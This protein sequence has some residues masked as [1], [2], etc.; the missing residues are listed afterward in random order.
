MVNAV[1][2]ISAGLLVL[3]G[4][5]VP[6]LSFLREILLQW[7]TILAAFALLVGVTNL[8]MVHG[9]KVGKGGEAAIYSFVTI[10][11]FVLTI[12][13]VGINKPTGQWSTRI[14]NSIT[15]PVENSL[16]ALLSISLLYAVMRLFRRKMDFYTIIFIVTMIL[17]LL[18][19]APL[20]GWGEIGFLNT[21]HGWITGIFALAGARGI[22][23]GVALGIV[24]TGLRILMGAD[25][26]Y[27]G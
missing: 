15:M 27:G 26:P 25:R 13:V 11:A 17:V 3:I 8:L 5:F 22:L 19:A 10:L 1:I 24:A 9:K 14:F 21:L 2:A 20:Y 23:L 4:Y 6:A 18:S 12:L 16:L 7:A